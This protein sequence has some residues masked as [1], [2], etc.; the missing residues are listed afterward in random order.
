MQLKNKLETFIEKEKENIKNDLKKLVSVPSV[1]NSS[2]GAFPFGKECAR[3]LETALEI[4]SDYGFECE[5][6]DYYCGSIMLRSKTDKE[7]GMVTH[8]D[9]VPAGDGWNFPPFDLSEKDGLYIGRGTEDDKGPTIAALY[10]LKFFKENNIELPFSL[11]MIMG[12]DEEQGMSDLSYYLT[13]KEPPFFSFTPD[14]GY[15]V[16]VGEKGILGAAIKICKVGDVVRSIKGGNASNSVCDHVV[17]L[18]RSEKESLP[19][20]KNISVSKLTDGTWEITAV[21]KTS[22]A[23]FP[24]G[25]VNAIKVLSDYIVEN[26]I[27]DSNQEEYKGMKYLS[28]ILEGYDGNGLGTKCFDEES[29]ELTCIGG[30]IFEK[31]GYV[32]QDINIRYPVTKKGETIKNSLESTAK[33]DGFEA[34]V[35]YY[36]EPYYFSPSKPE[37]QALVNAYRTVTGR[38]EGTYTTGGGTYARAFPNTVAFGATFSDSFGKLGEGRGG[39]HERDEYITIEELHSSIKIFVH[40]ILNIAELS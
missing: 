24:N 34:T 11:R 33:N 27:I 6:I 12:C 36:K 38:N 9:V 3:V 20:A 25:S 22:H 23:A 10:T 14:V 1:G 7:L 21:G 16:C 17:A 40:A 13:K 5:N 31:D 26:N 8:L 28:K 29:G 39:C 30:M 18:I 4:G 37:I 15:P 35:Y 32:I 19:S 2:D